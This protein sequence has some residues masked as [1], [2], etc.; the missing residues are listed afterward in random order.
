MKSR[1]RNSEL[2]VDQIKSKSL[3]AQEEKALS[4]FIQKLKGKKAKTTGKAA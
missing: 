1:K 2:D 3:T 4:E